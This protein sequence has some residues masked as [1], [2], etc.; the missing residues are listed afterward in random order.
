[1]ALQWFANGCRVWLQVV[2]PT[3][4]RYAGYRFYFFSRE[5]LRMHVH[6]HCGDGEAKFWLEPD[7]ELVKNYRLSKAQV[8]EIAALIRSHY[9]ELKSAWEKHFGT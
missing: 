6:V 9:D 1:M 5:E 3:V 7:V 8:A 2:S 4:F